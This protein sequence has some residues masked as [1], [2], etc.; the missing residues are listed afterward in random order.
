LLSLRSIKRR[1]PS[2][3]DA[4][5][6]RL[7]ISQHLILLS[8]AVLLPQVVLSTV[9]AWQ[10]ASD[11]RTAVETGA[12]VEAREHRANLDR[13]LKTLISM[14]EVLATSPALASQDLDGFR[15]QMVQLLT[16]RGLAMNL[17]DA[18][19][20]RLIGVSAGHV[21]DFAENPEVEALD[22]KVIASRQ[23]QVSG[24]LADP[25]TGRPY[26]LVLVPVL[27]GGEVTGV[28]DV[29][30]E[31]ANILHVVLRDVPDGWLASVVD[32]DLRII[33][34]SRDPD[35]YIGRPGT[36]TFAQGV[37]T[38]SGSFY[39]GRSIE[40]E[41]VFTAYQRSEISGWIVSF[42][43]PITLLDKPL[44]TLTRT[45][46]AFGA[47]GVGTSLLMA[48]IYARVL[49]RALRGLARSAAAVGR[50]PFTE[51]TQTRV[52]EID[53]VGSVLTVADAELKRSS[54]RQTTLLAELDHRV[55]NTLAII[56]SLVSQTFRS[57]RSPEQF[58]TAITG[59]VMALARSHEVLST[60]RWERPELGHV[61]EAILLRESHQ[62]TFNGPKVLLRPKAVVA[63]SQAFHELLAN[64]VLHGSLR[65]PL[66]RIDL[67]WSV[68]EASEMLHI[69][70]VETGAR[71]EPVGKLRQGLGMTIVRICIE[72]QL[73]GECDFVEET[74]RFVFWA[75]VPMQSELGRNATLLD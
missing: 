12:R 41:E 67:S 58:Q 50:D 74:D 8:L 32:A 44:T 10:Y 31:P 61:A 36:E 55:K 27:T 48:L 69:S 11:Q 18:A 34:R 65:N 37:R 38:G 28:L 70:W 53:D 25:P 40:G 72:R 60:A 51:P 26:L 71:P 42:A 63:F 20:H 15:G 3:S 45:L 35:R 64:A 21:G 24:L 73:A 1:D 2:R 13:E 59:R 66:G 23:P 9:V 43:V 52:Q 16:Q 14:L 5:G 6:W 54:T 39:G 46:M 7:T 49:S 62:V 47:L 22:R 68:D 29:A 19:G 57:A 4:A 30:L 17:R 33:T 56:Q 75:N